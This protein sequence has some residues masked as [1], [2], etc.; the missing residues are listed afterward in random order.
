MPGATDPRAFGKADF[1]GVVFAAFSQT[2]NNMQDPQ[3]LDLAPD[4]IP[5]AWARWDTYGLA[6]S[7]YDFTY[8]AACEA[9]NIAFVGGTTASVLFQ[10]EVDAADFLDQAGRNAAGSL[11]PH[12]EIRGRRL[13]C[14]SREC[15]VPTAAH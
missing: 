1:S 9:E 14:E 5:R 13:P 12:P 10:D 7:D 2:G 8:P 15:R 4:L 3:V 11:V 6:A